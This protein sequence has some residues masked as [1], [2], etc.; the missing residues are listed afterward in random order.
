MRALKGALEP[1]RV[2][3]PLSPPAPAAVPIPPDPRVEPLRTPSHLPVP[4][5]RSLL[6]S[7]P[8]A[9]RLTAPH[10]SDTPTPSPGPPSARFLLAP[11]DLRNP[12]PKA[13]PPPW[14]PSPG[15]SPSNPP[16]HRQPRPR[17]RT[18]RPAP[19]RTTAA[20]LLPAAG[21]GR[22]RRAPTRA[23]LPTPA[24]ARSNVSP[25]ISSLSRRAFLPSLGDWYRA[26][27]GARYLPSSGSRRADV[28]PCRTLASPRQ[29][30]GEQVRA[31][32]A[33]HLALPPPRVSLHAHPASPGRVKESLS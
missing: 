20:M 6:S 33:G 27:Q 17:P 15:L 22:A 21:A 10:P 23:S 28:V 7:C 25:A 5:A 16:Q 12:P 14:P 9:P 31:F 26:R 19:S 8:L 18:P 24:L 13:P 2:S 29:S 4:T 32:P 11:S 30:F 1:A 3:R